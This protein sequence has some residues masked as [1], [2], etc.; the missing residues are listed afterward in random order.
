MKSVLQVLQKEINL[1]PTD[2]KCQRE[3]EQR[4]YQLH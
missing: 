2:K 3:S 1:L 4:T